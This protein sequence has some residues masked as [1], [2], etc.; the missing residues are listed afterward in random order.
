MI[1]VITKAEQYN[2]SVFNGRLVINKPVAFRTK[3]IV[4]PYS[5]LFYWSLGI[6]TEDCEFGLHPHE[7]FEIM[8]IIRMILS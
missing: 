2:S 1:R 5:H 6:A 7:G 3:S 4:S 8:T